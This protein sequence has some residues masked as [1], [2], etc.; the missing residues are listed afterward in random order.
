MSVYL[1]QD[2]IPEV[3]DVFFTIR[4]C[5]SNLTPFRVLHGLVDVRWQHLVV[6]PVMTC[7]DVGDLSIK[8]IIQRPTRA[9]ALEFMNMNTLAARSA[10]SDQ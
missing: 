6:G 4:A 8:V 2:V 5:N 10:V 9:Q 7:C 3:G 1:G